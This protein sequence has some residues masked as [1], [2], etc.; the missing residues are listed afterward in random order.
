M[1]P[2]GD[3]SI[4]PSRFGGGGADKD[5][6]SWISSTKT[7]VKAVI[8]NEIDSTEQLLKISNFQRTIK[9]Q[10]TTVFWSN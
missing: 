6:E 3:F 4:M 2:C 10:P 8:E 9:D 7:V 1:K 5:I